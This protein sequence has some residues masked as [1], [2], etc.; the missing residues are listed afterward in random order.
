MT[1]N[2]NGLARDLWKVK[3]GL[4]ALAK[5]P[6]MYP[7]IKR[8]KKAGF[9]DWGHALM[10]LGVE[11]ARY[12]AYTIVH[13]LVWGLVVETAVLLGVFGVLTMQYI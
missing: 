4:K 9:K 8:Y 3:N 11:G 7:H 1:K 6:G 10:N 12:D 5:N 13:L 2:R